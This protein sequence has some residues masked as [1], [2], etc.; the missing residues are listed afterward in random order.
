[1]QQY[2][3]DNRYCMVSYDQTLAAYYSHIHQSVHQTICLYVHWSI[4]SRPLLH[5]RWTDFP[6]GTVGVKILEFGA[7][8]QLT[9][10]FKINKCLIYC[11]IPNL[12]IQSCS[13][14][15]Y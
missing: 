1:M 5:D 6:W 10:L 13:R 8:L 11:D 14:K 9:A 4:H 7:K 2:A 12:N 3:Y 15:E